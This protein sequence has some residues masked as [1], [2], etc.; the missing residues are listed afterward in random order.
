M[1]KNLSRR[2]ILSIFPV[3]AGVFSGCTYFQDR[4]HTI[5]FTAINH[6]DESFTAYLEIHKDDELL[7][8]QSLDLPSESPDP[9]GVNSST[10]THISLDSTIRT[11]ELTAEL[12]IDENR[13]E[14]VEFPANCDHGDEVGFRIHESHIDS[15]VTCTGD[16]FPY[17]N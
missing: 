4:Q 14:T 3:L 2:T 10:T 7:V 13:S 1:E 8:Q 6:T 15:D 16:E 17:D 12:S 5:G 9:D 11:A